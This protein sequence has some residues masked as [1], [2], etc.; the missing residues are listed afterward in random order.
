VVDL[1]QGQL[2]GSVAVGKRPYAVA[3]AKGRGFTT[4]QYGDGFGL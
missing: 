3:L 4:D 2:L 1:K